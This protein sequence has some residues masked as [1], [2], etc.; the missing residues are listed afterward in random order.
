M[1]TPALSKLPWVTLMAMSPVVEPVLPT[2]TPAASNKSPPETVK[3]TSPP[4]VR[5]SESRRMVPLAPPEYKVT[6]PVVA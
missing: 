4:V 3:E 1:T 5:M 6:V 2:Y